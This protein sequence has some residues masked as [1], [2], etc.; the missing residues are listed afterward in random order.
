[1]ES[2]FHSLCE[3]IS[4]ASVLT[5]PL[6]QHVTSV[7]TDASRLGIGSVLQVRRGYD[8]EAAV[9]FS[10]QTR[11]AEQRYS[12]TELEALVLIETIR[13]F[14]YY[15]YGKSCVVYTH[16]KSLCQL[17]TFDRLNGC[18]RR[19]GLKLQHRLVEVCYVLGEKNGMADALSLEK[20]AR[21]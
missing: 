18:L 5:I 7:V 4:N 14:A 17:L 8:W 3:F 11:E 12:T 1:M 20:N 6:P 2:A 21:H 16:H 13:H 15:L 19:L 9:F 10:Y